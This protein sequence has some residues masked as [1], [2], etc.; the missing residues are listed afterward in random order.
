MHFYSPSLPSYH[1]RLDLCQI[2]Y[3]FVSHQPFVI[4]VLKFSLSCFFYRIVGPLEQPI[5]E[6]KSIELFHSHCIC[7]IFNL[8]IILT[9]GKGSTFKFQFVLHEKEELPDFNTD[10]KAIK[11][12]VFEFNIRISTK[13]YLNYIGILSSFI[14]RST[15]LHG[16]SI[17]HLQ[18]I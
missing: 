3:P 16:R 15:L 6:H 17:V 4:F 11:I 2:A 9:F 12:I 14:D 8:K 13:T 5:R 10:R 1:Y 7:T 18:S